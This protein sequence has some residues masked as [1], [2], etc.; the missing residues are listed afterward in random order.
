MTYLCI[1][2]QYFLIMEYTA[3]IYCM[4]EQGWFHHHQLMMMDAD[5]VV[6]ACARCLCLPVPFICCVVLVLCCLVRPFELGA[7]P[8][9]AAPD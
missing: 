1:D 4:H 7:T 8:L 9:S 3:E 6:P 5:S 2:M